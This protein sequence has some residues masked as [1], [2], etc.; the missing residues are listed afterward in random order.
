M[1]HLLRATDCYVS[2]EGVRMAECHILDGFEDIL[3]E[4]L[5]PLQRAQVGLPFSAG[6]CGLRNP[7]FVRPA[8]RIAALAAF[9]THGAQAVG[10]LEYCR[11]VNAAQVMPVLQELQGILGP[12]FDPLPCWL[13]PWTY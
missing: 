3:G 9:H 10:A 11:H 2:D 6:G 5:P 7:L 8:A 12:N 4:A 13:V 1:V